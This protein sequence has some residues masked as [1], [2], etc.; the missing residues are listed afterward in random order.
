MYLKSPAVCAGG[1]SVPAAGHKAGRQL[2][3]VHGPGSVSH[4]PDCVAAGPEIALLPR[5]CWHYRNFYRDCSCCLHSAHRCAQLHKL[6]Q[7]KFCRPHRGCFLCSARGSKCSVSAAGAFKRS[8]GRWSQ[9]AGDVENLVTAAAAA[10]CWDRR[11]VSA[12]CAAAGTIISE[13]CAS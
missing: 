13:A 9:L 3:W 12:A 7:H 8:F 1:Q 10:L 4:G 11:S 2:W 5:L 6:M